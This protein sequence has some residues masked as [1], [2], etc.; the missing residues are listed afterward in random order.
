MDATVTTGRRERV[1]RRSFPP[2]TSSARLLRV[3]LARYLAEVEC[4]DAETGAVMLCAD[5]ALIN[6]VAHA[7]ETPVLVASWLRDDR[8]VVEVSDEG[9][10][11]DL[12]KMHGDA[13]PDLEAE[14]GR[15]LFLIHQLMDGVHID[16]SGHGTTIRME[17]QLAPT[18][19]T[20]AA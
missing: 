11:F 17:L 13:V 7:P 20:L 4:S 10:G 1:F 12:A 18:Q 6:A 14:H 5:E 15:G 2:H 16:S 9:P 19:L 8:L 3:T